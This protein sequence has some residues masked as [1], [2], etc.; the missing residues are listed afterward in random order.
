MAN[1]VNYVQNCPNSICF[2]VDDTTG[3]ENIVQCNR[4]D[5]PSSASLDGNLF[6][7]GLSSNQYPERITN[8]IWFA[9]I[10]AL[11]LFIIYQPKIFFNL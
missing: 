2:K 6:R 9:L 11:F 1:Q 3:T 8:S 5:I 4:F 7:D 10:V